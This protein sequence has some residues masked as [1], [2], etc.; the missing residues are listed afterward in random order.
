MVAK[1]IQPSTSRE[2]SLRATNR[3]TAG[4]SRTWLST[5]S[6]IAPVLSVEWPHMA[7]S[8]PGLGR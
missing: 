1:C 5:S 6:D 3:R 2:G 4:T 7:A 8:A